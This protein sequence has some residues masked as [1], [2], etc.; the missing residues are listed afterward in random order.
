MD[1]PLIDPKYEPFLRAALITLLV[2]GFYAFFK[3]SSKFTRDTLSKSLYK[4]HRNWWYL[5]YIFLL[6]IVGL[7]FGI[8]LG[9]PKFA[10]NFDSLVIPVVFFSIF[11]T[12]FV[13]GLKKLRSSHIELLE[14]ELHTKYG[15]KE[16][17]I[18]YDQI[19]DAYYHQGYLHIVL[20]EKNRKGMH[21][22]K[23]IPAIFEDMGALIE[24][25]RQRAST[26]L[27]NKVN[28]DLGLPPNFRI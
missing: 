3:P 19:L 1:T 2:F 18:P 5:C 27:I 28:T 22:E 12:V 4:P 9:S 16:N 11:F 26:A 17:R 6:M 14:G 15:R 13:L 7:S 21:K 24:N 23:M 10:F 25:I 20:T 8:A